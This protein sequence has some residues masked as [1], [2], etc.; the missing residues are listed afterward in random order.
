MN[1]TNI[2]ELSVNNSKVISFSN[3]STFYFYI[4]ELIH[5]KNSFIFGYL[6]AYTFLYYSKKGKYDSIV[7][8]P[9]GV[10]MHYA[11]RFLFPKNYLLKKRIISTDLWNGLL[12]YVMSKDMSCYFYGGS[13]SDKQSF[14]DKMKA[15]YP[16]LKIAGLTNGFEEINA[17]HFNNLS[18][19]ILFLGRGTPKQEEWAQN[20]LEKLKIPIVILV[21]SAIDYWSG[22]K[23]RAPVCMQKIGMEWLYRIYK[24][25]S[26]LWRRYII[27]I[28]VFIFKVIQ[29]KFK[30]MLKNENT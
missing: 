17:S 4:E 9:D 26:R 24:E 8:L 7:F 5:L 15:K 10:A 22:E 29:Y 14:K 30:L 6:N 16:G 20:N 1:T 3:Y 11:L 12:G 18:V 21:G 23:K 2:D 19:D 25:P 28:P 13:Y 27:G